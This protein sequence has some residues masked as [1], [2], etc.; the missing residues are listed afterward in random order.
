[1]SE[2]LHDI[3]KVKITNPSTGL[4]EWKQIPAIRGTSVYSLPAIPTSREIQSGG[5]TITQYGY[6][7]RVLKIN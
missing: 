1:M 2:I 3:L 4:P 5:T 7:L 6:I